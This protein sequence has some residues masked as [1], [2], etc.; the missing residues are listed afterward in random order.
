[1]KRP[2][3]TM[4]LGSIEIFVKAAELLSFTLSARELGISPPAVSRSIA[5]LEDRLGVRLFARSTR[6]MRLTDDGRLYFEE[7]RQILR[8]LADAENALSGAGKIP[9][10]KLRVSMPTTYGHHRVLL[11]LPKFMDAYPEIEIEVNVSNR[12]IDFVEEGYDIAIRLGVPEDSRLIARK[13]EDAALGVFASPALFERHP[14]PSHP[15]DLAHLPL[16]LFKMPSTGKPLAW[17]FMIDGKL[18]E[19]AFD[20]RVCV[21]DDVLACT[22]YARNGGALVQT[23]DFI[24][25]PYVERGE[26]VEVLKDY[27]GPSRP[28]SILYPQNRHL[29][30]RVRA[31][32]AF[33]LDSFKTP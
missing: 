22:T 17:I 32:V 27:R 15:R 6:Q 19:F 28:F 7:C 21:S 33:L 14:V 16:V 9:S 3:D 10:G 1:M 25:R 2:F 4:Q 20:S 11:A 26:L 23:Y 30:S 29:S 5:R 12:N 13:I 24:A 31:F 8:Q 18:T